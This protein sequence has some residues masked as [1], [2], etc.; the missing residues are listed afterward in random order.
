MQ[1]DTLK[2]DLGDALTREARQ[3]LSA[4]ELMAAHRELEIAYSEAMSLIQVSHSTFANG[5]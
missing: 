2:E 5:G 4:R 1:Y 3:A